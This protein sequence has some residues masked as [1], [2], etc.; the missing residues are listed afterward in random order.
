MITLKLRHLAIALSKLPSHPCNS[1]ELE[2]YQ[3]E[4]DLAALWLAQRDAHDGLEGKRVIGISWKSIKSLNTLKK[5][6]TL[7]EF[8]KIFEGLDVTLVNLQ[9]GDVDKEIREFEEE[10]GIKIVQCD[11]VDNRED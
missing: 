6:L 9:Y 4:G 7:L 10:T 8:G 3:T 11:S 2:Q 1:V 5:S